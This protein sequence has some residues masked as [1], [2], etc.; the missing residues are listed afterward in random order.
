MGITYSLRW[1]MWYDLAD[2]GTE[3]GYSAPSFLNIRSA[4]K[5]QIHTLVLTLQGTYIGQ[6]PFTLIR[7]MPGDSQTL[8]LSNYRG[9]MGD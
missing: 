9:Y 4:L 1:D 5:K 2:A 8:G 3:Y 6:S 7:A